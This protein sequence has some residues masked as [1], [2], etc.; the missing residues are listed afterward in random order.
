[1]DNTRLRT[2]FS[3]YFDQV[4]SE[5]EL[6]ELEAGLLATAAAREEFRAMARLYALLQLWGGQ[7]ST[8]V[9]SGAQRL[10]VARNPEARMQ[11]PRPKEIPETV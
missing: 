4:L 11:P 9:T 8:D 1:M 2:L 7:A 6:T 10:A 3:R 5:A